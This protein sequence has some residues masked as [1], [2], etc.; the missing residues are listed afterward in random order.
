MKLH[1]PKIIVIDGISGSGKST[2]AKHFA[3]EFGCTVI[4]GDEIMLNALIDFPEIGKA[5]C[6]F[7]PMA[8]DTGLVYLDRHYEPLTVDKERMLY[9]LTN[10]YVDGQIQWIM[11]N[12]TTEFI[13]HPKLHSTVSV[14]Q[15]NPAGIIIEKTAIN[16]LKSPWAGSDARV[17]IESDKRTREEKLSRRLRY[18]EGYQQEDMAQIRGIVHEEFLSSI[19]NVDFSFLNEYT[20]ESKIIGNKGLQSVLERIN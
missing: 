1:R 19:E 11:D 13:S 8:G 15:P 6:G 5:I 4:S 18:E 7:Y 9:E 14:F 10:E 17:L 2:F 20:E 16:K 3:E 12:P